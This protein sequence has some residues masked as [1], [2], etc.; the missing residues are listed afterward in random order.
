MGLAA[1]PSKGNGQAPIRAVAARSGDDDGT[2][3]VLAEALA[4]CQLARQDRRQVAEQ[5]RAITTA[6]PPGDGPL[7]ALSG[8]LARAADLLDPRRPRRPR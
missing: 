8:R 2:A 1:R 5:L 4:G 7:A 3:S 6:L